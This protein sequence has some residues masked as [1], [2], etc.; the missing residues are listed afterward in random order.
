MARIFA[1]IRKE[2]RLYLDD[3]LFF[4]ATLCLIAGTTLVFIDMPYIYLQENVESS[5]QTPPADFLTQLIRSEKIQD[6]GTVLLATTIFSVKFSF[7]LF[8]RHLLRLQRKLIYYWW[9]ICIILIP[10]AAVFMFLDFI[11]CDYFDE[12]IVSACSTP[13]ALARQNDSLLASA[14]LDILTDCFLISIPII[15]LWNIQISIRQKLVLCGILCLS[16]V[17][18]IMAIIRVSTGK[19]SNGQL[20]SAWVGGFPLPFL[21]HWRQSRNTDTAKLPRRKNPIV[22]ISSDDLFH[23]KRPRGRL[24]DYELG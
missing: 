14:I 10:S 18:I 4:L 9:F 7:L 8:F 2:Q 21:A 6:A 5:R 11:S 22:P 24:A 3:A 13:G 15:L 1:R 12:R 19:S 23:R 17:M 16:V 20:D